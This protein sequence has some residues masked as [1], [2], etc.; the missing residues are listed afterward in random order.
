VKRALNDATLCRRAEQASAKALDACVG[1]SDWL[2][3]L[4]GVAAVVPRGVCHD[5]LAAATPR[6]LSDYACAP[7]AGGVPQTAAL[8]IRRSSWST[9][10]CVCVCAPVAAFVVAGMLT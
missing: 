4:R 2:G 9:Q 8:T 7:S 6:I 3:A 1:A 10:Q 5:A